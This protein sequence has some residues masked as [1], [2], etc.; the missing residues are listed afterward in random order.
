VGGIY[1]LA[2]ANLLV[3][4]LVIWDD[5]LM[6]AGGVLVGGL[7]LVVTFAMIRR[8]AFAGARVADAAG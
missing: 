8:G 6:R 3:H 7:T 2:L 4:G 1:L 5:P